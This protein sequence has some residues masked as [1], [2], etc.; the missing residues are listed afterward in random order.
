MRATAARCS[1]PASPFDPRLVGVG[2]Y[3]EDAARELAHELLSQPERPTAIFASN[4][5]SAIAVLAV[6]AELGHLGA[7]T[8]SR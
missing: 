2:R 4:D 3:Q 8:S 5:L 6:A 1:R 7:A